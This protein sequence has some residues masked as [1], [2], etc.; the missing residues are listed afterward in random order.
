MTMCFDRDRQ[1][2]RSEGYYRQ[3]WA[4]VSLQGEEEGHSKRK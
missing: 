3:K 4:T 1:L 2:P